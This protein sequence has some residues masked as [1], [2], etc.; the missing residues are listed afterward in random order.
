M[1]FPVVMYGCESWT[2]N[3]AERLRI[4]AFALWCWRKLL[5]VPWTVRGS[6]Q[7][8]LNIS[9]E[10]SP[11]YHWK[12]WCWTWNSS[13][14]ATGCEELTHWKRPW[15]WERLRAGGEGDNRDGWMAS[16]TQ[17]TRVSKLQELVMY[18]EA[19]CSAVLGVTKSWTQ[20]SNWTELNWREGH[21]GNV[22]SSCTVLWLVDSEVARW[23]H[24][25]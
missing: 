7:F 8:I 1:F 19:W 15:C 2:I 6:N 13:T 22:I 3:K 21:P 11:E 24:R 16:P 14:L 23:Y 9:P 12:D 5:R 17:G 20:L 25:G 10:I 18:R 4:D